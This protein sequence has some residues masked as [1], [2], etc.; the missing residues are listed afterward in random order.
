MH[1]SFQSLIDT[2]ELALCQGQTQPILAIM[3]SL[4]L[5]FPDSIDLTAA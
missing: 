4:N 2:L 5:S 1:L 3:A